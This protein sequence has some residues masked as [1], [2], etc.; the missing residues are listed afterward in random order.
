M[1]IGRSTYIETEDRIAMRNPSDITIVQ[2]SVYNKQL[3][4]P[5]GTLP[6]NSRVDHV[7]YTPNIL[8]LRVQ[9][10]T[11]RKSLELALPMRY[12]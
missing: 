2:W 8:L 1:Q 12:L 9:D 11:L 10:R 4:Y 6:E 5:M 7:G 3:P